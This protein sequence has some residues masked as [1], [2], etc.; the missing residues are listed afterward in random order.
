[1]IK[2]IPTEI[3]SEG[4]SAVDGNLIHASGPPTPLKS[5]PIGQTAGP[6]GG[7]AFAGQ[8]G[9]RS[10]KGYPGQSFPL[11]H[12]AGVGRNF[13]Q[14]FYTHELKHVGIAD[15]LKLFAAK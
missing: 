6:G 10:G 2:L 14:Q 11:G 5:A 1:L 3:A 7:L 8:T 13:D 4:E 9:M 12:E 15:P